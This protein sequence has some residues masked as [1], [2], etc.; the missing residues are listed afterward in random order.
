MLPL[1][2]Q[3]GNREK[4]DHKFIRGFLEKIMKSTGSIYDS[5]QGSFDTTKGDYRLI[6]VLTFDSRFPNF[7]DVPGLMFSF[8]EY[9]GLN[10]FRGLKKYCSPRLMPILNLH[11]S[12]HSQIE[13]KETRRKE[14]PDISR[15][16]ILKEYIKMLKIEIKKEDVPDSLLFKK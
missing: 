1:F 9:F 13:T 7:N 6:N 2:E 12:I 8:H 5:A 10:I 11:Q 16:F 15:E 14:N 4:P 3:T